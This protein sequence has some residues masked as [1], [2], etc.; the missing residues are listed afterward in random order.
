[1]T[2]VDAFDELYDSSNF[3]AESLHRVRRHRANGKEKPRDQKAIYARERAARYFVSVDGEGIETETGQVY[4]LLA[5]SDGSSVVNMHGLTTRQCCEFLINLR[6][7]H[8]NAIFI[9]FYFEYDI[10]MILRGLPKKKLAALNKYRSIRWGKY[11]LEHIPRKWFTVSERRRDMKTRKWVTVHTTRIYDT[12]GFF[13]TSFIDAMQSI[14]VLQP[15]TPEY[16]LLSKMKQER[17]DFHED[18]WEIIEEYNNLEMRLLVDAL[19][20]LRSGMQTLGI[21]PDLWHGAGAIA[22]KMLKKMA[23]KPHLVPMPD[24]VE[25][26]CRYAFFGGRIETTMIGDTGPIYGYDINSAYPYGLAELPSLEDGEWKR[27]KGAPMLYK[28]RNPFI[29]CHVHW[30]LLDEERFPIGIL[31]VRN[32]KGAVGFP[33]YG[34]G[35]YWID[36]VMMAIV[37]APKCI[38]I[39]EHCICEG[40]DIESRPLQWIKELYYERLK[41]KAEGRNAEQLALKLGLNSLYG[42]MAQRVSMDRKPPYQH[43]A[44]AG[45]TTARTRSRLLMAA[46]KNPFAIIAFA[47]DGIYTSEPLDVKTGKGFGRWEPK[48][49]SDS[50]FLMPGMYCLID[51]NGNLTYKAR[52]ISRREADWNAI[53]ELWKLRGPNI[54]LDYIGK[55]FIGYKSALARD[56]MSIH[57]TW[58]HQPRTLQAGSNKYEIKWWKS[59]EPIAEWFYHNKVRTRPQYVSLDYESRPY[60]PEDLISDPDSFSFESEHEEENFLQWA[61]I[62]L[63]N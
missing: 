39:L 2:H 38:T 58:I 8:P 31:P 4:A 60:R 3:P 35:W 63:I 61:D 5:A 56:D 33:R 22:Q 6:I 23:V 54:T 14:G 11:R 18:M 29:L 9:A 17:G 34:K 27:Y 62:T 36:E 53:R 10:N 24:E 46:Y 48:H 20:I 25:L 57:A 59:D 44:Y 50:F 28:N 32:S 19:D 55:A 37:A 12:Q 30:K 21:E 40:I 42:K 16:E 49:Y 41:L 52:G 47:T 7:Q 51:D 45:V 13:Q 43:Y 15:D 1:M 26:L